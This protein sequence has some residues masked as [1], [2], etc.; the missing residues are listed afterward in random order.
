MCLYI[1]YW[2]LCLGGSV[3]VG[4]VKIHAKDSLLFYVHVS[5]F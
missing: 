5:C 4:A 1:L 3:F 2:M